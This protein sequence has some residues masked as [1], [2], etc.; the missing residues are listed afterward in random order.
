N[1]VSFISVLPNALFIAGVIVMVLGALV[2]V[3]YSE[4]AV[5]GAGVVWGTGR[6]LH[7]TQKERFGRTGKQFFFMLFMV[8]TGIILIFLGYL[9]DVL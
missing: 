7:R 1:N 4:R 3:G 9:I 2:G 8:T 6:Y 5:Y